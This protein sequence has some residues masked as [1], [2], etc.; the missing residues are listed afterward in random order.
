MHRELPAYDVKPTIRLTLEGK[1]ADGQTIGEISL[2]RIYAFCTRS[3]GSCEEA[4]DHFAKGIAESVKERDRP[5]EKG[6]VRLAIRPVDYVDR[7]KKQK[8]SGLAPVYGRP[9]GGGLAVVP[10]LDYTRTIRFVGEKDLSK[11]EVSEDELFR[12]GEQN[13]R[14]SIRPLSDVTPVLGPNSFGTFTGEDYASTR[15]VF[16]DEWKSLA[17]KLKGNLI[18][19]LPTPDILLYGDGSTSTGVDAMRTFGLEMARKSTR[20][21]STVVLRWA[22]TG[23]EVAR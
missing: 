19:M 18:V 7:L 23:W 1:S 14:K 13:V 16:H 3:P 12:L 4:L 2:D 17:D 10:V 15:I 20:P 6:M 11:L 5:I 21:L 8:G 22:P 9:V